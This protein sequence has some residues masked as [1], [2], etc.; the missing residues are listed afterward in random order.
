MRFVAFAHLS[1]G[2]IQKGSPQLPLQVPHVNAADGF[3]SETKLG[4]LEGAALL[5]G[6]SSFR[7]AAQRSSYKGLRK[8]VDGYF[9]MQA[10]KGD[11]QGRTSEPH[12]AEE[13]SDGTEDES[14]QAAPIN[15]TTILLVPLVF[16]CVCTCVGLCMSP[17]IIMTPLIAPVALG[18]IVVIVLILMILIKPD[19]TTVLRA[20]GVI[21]L[22][23]CCMPVLCDVMSASTRP[24][25]PDTSTVR[26]SSSG[27]DTSGPDKFFRA[28]DALLEALQQGDAD[29]IEAACNQA[30]A[31]GVDGQW[32]QKQRSQIELPLARKALEAALQHG[33]ADQIEAACNRAEAAGVDAQLVQ[34]GRSKVESHHRAR[35]ALA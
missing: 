33:D 15:L 26:T 7:N 5:A 1:V 8:V 6:R 3:G 34:E 28:R 31:A 24:R 25:A 18:L 30:E 13:E 2:V 27:Q 22:L 32:V 14:G 17:G 23:C 19:P 4:P 11:A 29:Q 35:S 10:E 20:I 16:C 12:G 21:L 9:P